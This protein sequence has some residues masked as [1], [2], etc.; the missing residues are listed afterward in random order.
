MTYPTALVTVGQAVMDE[1]LSVTL[2]TN[3]PA[4]PVSPHSL[5]ASTWQYAAAA[6]GIVNSTTPVTIKAAGTSRLYIASIDIMAEILTVATE[7]VI[8][9]GAGGPVLWRTKIGTAGLQSGRNIRFP[10]PLRGSTANLLEVVTLTATI[11]GAVY[12]NAQGY[13]GP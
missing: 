7:L 13:E 10:I 1:S 4:I 2:A 5:P 12:F 9:D 6:S 3:H 8:R 11:L